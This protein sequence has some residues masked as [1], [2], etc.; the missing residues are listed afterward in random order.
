MQRL[1]GTIISFSY[2]GNIVL[3]LELLKEIE[4]GH[5]EHY[6]HRYS[7]VTYVYIIYIYIYVPR[8]KIRHNF[9]GINRDYLILSYPRNKLYYYNI[10]IFFSNKYLHCWAFLFS[11][12]N[13]LKKIRNC[14]T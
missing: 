3:M 6:A 12:L 9:Y 2:K 1:N 7:T 5:R 13:L 4:N 11:K 14:Y 10:L 8:N